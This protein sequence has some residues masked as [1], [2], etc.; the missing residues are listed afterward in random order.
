M[1]DDWPQ[2]TYEQAK[3]AFQAGQKLHLGDR[4]FL[5]RPALRSGT[6]DP[7]APGAEAQ[8]VLWVTDQRTLGDHGL[9]LFPD[10]RVEGK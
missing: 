1:T 2:I 4:I 7:S 9:L 5:V 10:G 8:P 6:A 3:G